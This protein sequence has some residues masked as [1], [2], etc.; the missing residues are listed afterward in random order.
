MEGA[1]SLAIAHDLHS[2]ALRAYNNLRA[3]LVGVDPLDEVLAIV[4][5]GLEL[6][7]RIGDRLW[8]SHFLAGRLVVLSEAGRW[9]EALARADELRELATTKFAQGAMLTLI[10]IYS[11]RGQ[12]ALARRVLEEQS[13]AAESGDFQ[14]VLWHQNMESTLLRAEGRLEESFSVAQRAFETERQLGSAIRSSH[15]EMLKTAVALG[16][17]DLARRHLA[18]LDGLHAGQLTPYLTAQ[19]ERF[20]GALYKSDNE[21][22][23]DTAEKGFRQLGFQFELAVTAFEHAGWLLAA[24]RGEE[25]AAPLSDAADIFQRLQAKPWLERLDAASTGAQAPLPA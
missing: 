20:R 15:I 16:D 25:A 18:T 8:E 4:E 6:A 21:L 11:A 1:L 22:H 14:F 10:P 24:R 2:A 3:T 7:R 23:F 5:A 19:R 13:A 17:I 12:L 9:D